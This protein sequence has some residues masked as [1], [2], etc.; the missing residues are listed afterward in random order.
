MKKYDDKRTFFSKSAYEYREVG[1][2]ITSNI[3]V[4]RTRWFR[5]NQHV[6]WDKIIFERP[7]IFGV[8][9]FLLMIDY[10]FS[11]SNTALSKPQFLQ[12]KGINT[13]SAFSLADFINF[14]FFFL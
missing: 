4:I 1:F 2:I 13:K 10:Q 5:A 14:L 11:F 3:C 12:K 6:F 8:A 9:I 7:E